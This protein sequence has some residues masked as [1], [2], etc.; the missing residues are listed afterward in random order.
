MNPA[1][2]VYIPQIINLLRQA[3]A[4]DNQIAYLTL[5]RGQISLIRQHETQDLS[6][7]TKDQAQGR[8]YD[9]IILDVV[10]PGGKLFSLDFSSDPRRMRVAASRAKIGMIILGSNDVPKYHTRTLPLWPYRFTY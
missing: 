6:M 9:F 10:T 7:A 1:N 3:D 4:A 5:Y 8:E 2:L